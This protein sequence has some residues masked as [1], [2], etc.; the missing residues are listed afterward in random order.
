MQ[1][2]T[3]TAAFLFTRGDQ[4]FPRALDFAG[5][6]D[7]VGGDADLPSKILQETK[8]GRCERITRGAGCERNL[9]NRL[10]LVDQREVE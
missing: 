10:G 7:G 1:I 2:T 6:P 5:Q 8:I 9:S 4:A 3:E